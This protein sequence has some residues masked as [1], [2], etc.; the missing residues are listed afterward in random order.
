MRR[1][2]QEI[3]TPGRPAGRFAGGGAVPQLL[4]ET[5]VAPGVHVMI[6]D[7]KEL[8]LQ[9][10][11]PHCSH[12]GALALVGPAMPAATRPAFIEVVGTQE[13]SSRLATSWRMPTV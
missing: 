10:R 13:A 2:L 5:H 1:Q 3:S 7:G 8:Q 6:C 9:C 11:L 12:S 4:T